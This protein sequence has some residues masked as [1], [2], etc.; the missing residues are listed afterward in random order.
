MHTLF[1]LM[2]PH[3][4]R[5]VVAAAFG[6]LTILASVFLAVASSWLIAMAALRPS[7]ADLSLGIVGVRGLGVGRAAFRYLERLTG[8]EATFRLLA[9]LR[10]RF[11]QRIEPLNGLQ[12]GQRHTG[13]LLARV[14][15]D[16]E[17]LQNVYLRAVGPFA[18]AVL[19]GIVTSALV[20]SFNLAAGLTVVILLILGGLVVPLWAHGRARDLGR[21]VVARRAD[22]TTDTV[23][24]VQGM[25]DALAYGVQGAHLSRLSQH[26]G[27]VREAEVRLANLDG[28]VNGLSALLSGA[29]LVGVLGLT[30]GS[31]GGVWLAALALA[32]QAAFEAFQPLTQAAQQWGTTEAAA[33]RLFDAQPS[34]PAHGLGV[35]TAFGLQL[36]RVLFGY[37][38][39]VPVIRDLTLDIPHG[40]HL[41]IVSP[42]GGGKSTLLALLTALST[43]QQG[44][45]RLGGQDLRTL[46]PDAVRAVMGVLPQRMHLFN[47]TLGDN[48]R[49]ARP[50]ADTEQVIQAAQRAHIHEAIAALP[51]GYESF[52][53]EGG[54]KFSGG[55]RQRV[56]LA[57]VFLRDA[58]IWVLDEPTAALDHATAAQ[59][60]QSVKQAAHGRTL[61]VLLHD[62]AQAE[63]IAF[64]RVIRL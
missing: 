13:D 20:L 54:A 38:P 61:I 63:G 48:I 3:L 35:P 43:P 49:L 1:E 47:T 17:T 6:A 25:A 55:Q 14:M 8:H 41:A 51:A 29:A 64:D 22:L 44:C 45:I 21:G 27:Q 31:V 33:H 40:Q 15:A 56:A 60:M 46:D 57:R 12:L 36:E 26:V 4:R 24:L 2:R 58:P 37:D 52:L 62:E 11:Y 42:S 34:P 9:D 28:W 5:F 32:A 16:V 10:V 30:V 18:V 19:V 39:R 50:D 23:E 7:I 53:G 59:V